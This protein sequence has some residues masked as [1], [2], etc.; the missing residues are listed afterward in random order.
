MSFIF[1]GLGVTLYLENIP[2]TFMSL[3]LRYPQMVFRMP[4]FSGVSPG[5]TSHDK[6]NLRFKN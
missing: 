3:Y 2:H 1:Q 6:F 5:D 4:L